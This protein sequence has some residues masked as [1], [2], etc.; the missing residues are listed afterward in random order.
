MEPH[1]GAERSA[2]RARLFSVRTL[3]IFAAGF[4][5]ALFLGRSMPGVGLF[6][7]EGRIITKD[8]VITAFNGYDGRSLASIQGIAT[9]DGEG[10]GGGSEVWDGDLLNEAVAMFDATGNWHF[11]LEARITYVIPRVTTIRIERRD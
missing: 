11:A 2:F 4:A 7:P 8:I 10:F 6:H 3:L 5:L 1:E 9:K